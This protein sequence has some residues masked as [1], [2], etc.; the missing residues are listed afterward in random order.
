[1]A[2]KTRR[3]STR[4]AKRGG[5]FLNKLNPIKAYKNRQTR[6]AANAAAAAQ[7][8]QRQ[9][10]LE[11]SRL[12]V[13]YAE[14]ALKNA[15]EGKTQ[16]KFASNLG[17]AM[18]MG[19]YRRYGIPQT[20]NVAVLQNFLTQAQQQLAQVQGGMQ[21]GGLLDRLKRMVASKEQLAANAAAK[22]KANQNRQ[23]ELNKYSRISNT[24]GLIKKIKA[25]NPPTWNQNGPF[26]PLY[27]RYR[28]LGI[29]ETTDAAVL[30]KYLANVK[31]TVA[32]V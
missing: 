20:T 16:N 15:Q 19:N 21:G 4:K 6:K 23:L 18:I 28:A 12:R 13:Y 29:P 10:M 8:A 7:Q 14:R 9:Q 27:N 30:E 11:N 2:R 17:S 22:A 26:K 5:G 25:G 24:E 1:M 3:S 32:Q 31:G